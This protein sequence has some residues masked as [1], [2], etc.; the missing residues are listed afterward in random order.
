MSRPPQ[1]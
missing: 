1:V